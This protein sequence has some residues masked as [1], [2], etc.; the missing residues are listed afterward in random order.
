[1][2]EEFGKELWRS[3]L[4]PDYK[5][6]G[7]IL[8]SVGIFFLI[9]PF[10][11]F[12]SILNLTV[13]RNVIIIYI[14]LQITFSIIAILPILIGT[15]F[16]ATYLIIYGNGIIYR[17]AYFLKFL[18]GHYVPFTEIQG[19][20]TKKSPKYYGSWDL[21]LG[22]RVPY[23]KKKRQL[24]GGYS[25][26]LIFIQGQRPHKISSAW[27]YP[28]EKAKELIS[29]Y[30]TRED[31]VLTC[32]Y[33]GTGKMSTRCKYCGQIYCKDCEETVKILS[34]DIACIICHYKNM[35]KRA[36]YSLIP[37]FLILFLYNFYVLVFNREIFSSPPAGFNY[38]GSLRIYYIYFNLLL[39]G[40][41]IPYGFSL[42]LSNYFRMKRIKSLKISKKKYNL[43]FSALLGG[44]IMVCKIIFY[45]LIINSELQEVF[46]VF[47]IDISLILI[48]CWIFFYLHHIR[49]LKF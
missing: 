27:V 45:I 1:M 36:L 37:S 38:L 47:I 14:L 44:I 12:L 48:F 21:K 15:Q 26:L 46:P 23:R 9:L 19:I 7:K 18:K 24:T 17:K 40:L 25:D 41:L 33:C 31:P 16:F 30:M 35:A 28:I 29:E 10:I 39:S 32:Y 43:Y 3:S 42:I 34:M 11:I 49:A 6:S 5:Q 8:V 13:S 4:H 2:K 20:E 22:Y